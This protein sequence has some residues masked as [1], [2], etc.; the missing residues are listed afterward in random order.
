MHT[1]SDYKFANLQDGCCREIADLEQ[2]LNQ[3]N[4]KQIVLLAYEKQ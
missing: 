4:G 2:K 1:N 3:D